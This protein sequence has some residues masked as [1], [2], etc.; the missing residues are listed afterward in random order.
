MNNWGRFFLVFVMWSVSGLYAADWPLPLTF[1]G[2][3]V[4]SGGVKDKRAADDAGPRCLNKGAAK[5]LGRLRILLTTHLGGGIDTSLLINSLTLFVHAISTID[6]E[7]AVQ[8]Q[9][10]LKEMMSNFLLS[11]SRGEMAS[12]EEEVVEE[13]FAEMRKAISVVGRHFCQRLPETVLYFVKA[14]Q[15]ASTHHAFVQRG[16]M[17]EV[18]SLGE[19]LLKNASATATRLTK[20]AAVGICIHPKE[21]ITVQIFI[22]SAAWLISART[23]RKQDVGD[24]VALKKELEE[25][26]MSIESTKGCA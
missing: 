5:R 19:L 10:T 13:L 25:C 14:L 17:E 24:L 8:I 21:R 4:A 7:T 1:L 12:Q 22:A 2:K 16:F 20:L 9:T 23:A 3:P 26:L 18:C 15:A 6:E 11:L